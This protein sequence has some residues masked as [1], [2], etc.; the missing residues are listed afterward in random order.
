MSRAPLHQHAAGA[1]REVTEARPNR[2]RGICVA[3]HLAK[4]SVTSAEKEI[5]PASA[6]TNWVV[7]IGLLFSPSA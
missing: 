7:I 2:Q 5:D 6:T 1:E 4:E 3:H